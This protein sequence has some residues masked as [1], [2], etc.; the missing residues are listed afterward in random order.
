MPADKPTRGLLSGNNLPDAAAFSDMEA[1][2]F[3]TEGCRGPFQ[4]GGPGCMA[5]QN[6]TWD[7]AFRCSGDAGSERPGGRG[8]AWEKNRSGEGVRTQ[9][10]PDGNPFMQRLLHERL[11]HAAPGEDPAVALPPVELGLFVQQD[12][13]L[14]FVVLFSVLRLSELLLQQG[15]IL[16]IPAGNGR[17]DLN[18]PPSFV[19]AAQSRPWFAWTACA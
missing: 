6:L 10:C 19:R 18:R 9:G 12:L 5:C 8:C 15:G 17:V 16:R 11:Q 7:P 4:K 13:P 3:C 2:V 1:A 14:L